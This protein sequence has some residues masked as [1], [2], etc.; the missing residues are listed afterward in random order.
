MPSV[1]P[2]DLHV[3]V[4][5]GPQ[6]HPEDPPGRLPEME[7]AAEEH[8]AVVEHEFVAARDGKENILNYTVHKKT[9][10]LPLMRILV[11]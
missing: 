2:V 8:L 10:M 1:G 3:V 6:R 11:S 9:F 4:Q 5:L 7:L